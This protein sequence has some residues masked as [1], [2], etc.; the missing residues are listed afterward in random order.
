MG[1]STHSDDGYTYPYPAHRYPLQQQSTSHGL[2][3][4]Q[5]HESPSMSEALCTSVPDLPEP[6]VYLYPDHSLETPEMSEELGA[7]L[8]DWSEASTAILPEHRRAT[9]P[10]A[11]LPSPPLSPNLT[12]IRPKRGRPRK[13]QRDENGKPIKP[14]EYKTPVPG[15]KYCI[16]G[17]NKGKGKAR[18]RNGK[19]MGKGKGKPGAG[20]S[21]APARRGGKPRSQRESRYTLVF[22]RG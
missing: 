1:I 21:R 10:R 9:E 2:D 11:Q 19:G 15:G 20:H 22:A 14:D 7:S 3:C 8:P 16:A 18:T 17:R 6:P 5:P 13:Y 12:P 4:C